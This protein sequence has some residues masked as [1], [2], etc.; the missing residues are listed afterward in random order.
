[1]K[2]DFTRLN[3]LGLG[4]FNRIWKRYPQLAK[5]L[6]ALDIADEDINSEGDLARA[7]ETVIQQIRQHQN[8]RWEVKRLEWRAHG[9]KRSRRWGER[10][11]GE[12]IDHPYKMCYPLWDGTG[13]TLYVSEPYTLAGEGIKHLAR[14]VDKGWD[15]TITAWRATHFPGHTLHVALHRP[16]TDKQRNLAGDILD[17]YEARPVEAA[18]FIHRNTNGGE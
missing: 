4:G 12:W 7:L 16:K 3:L 8:K 18:D 9:P 1:M 11:P 15:V 17:T 13:R 2:V 14:L 10:V 5:A 6:V